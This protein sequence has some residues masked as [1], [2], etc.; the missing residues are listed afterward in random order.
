MKRIFTWDNR[1]S[2]RRVPQQKSGVGGGEI[3]PQ[4]RL[5]GGFSIRDVGES[6]GD[7]AKIEKDVRVATTI[8]LVTL[9]KIEP[10]VAFG[11]R[12]D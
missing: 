9:L 5:R 1:L 11:R 12:T 7:A 6:H 4:D 3:L 8:T 10:T 2:A